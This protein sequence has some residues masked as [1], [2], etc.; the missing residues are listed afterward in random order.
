MHLERL[1]ERLGQAEHFERDVDAAS[2]G[3]LAHP[4]RRR[5]SVVAL[6]TS[7]APSRRAASSLSSRTSTAMICD[8]P[9]AV[10]NLDDVQPDAA[11]GD[12]RHAFAAAQVGA[13]ADGAVGGEHR[14]AQHRRFLRAAGSSGS[15]KTSVAGTTEYSASP[16]IEYIAIGV[17]SRAAQPRRAV[18][19]RAP[20]PVHREEVVAE[21]VAAGAAEPAAAAR[22]DER[23][24]DRACPTADR[25]R[26]ARARRRCRRSRAPAPPGV[27]KATSAFMTCRSV[28][29]TPHAVTLTSTSPASGSGIGISSMCSP[30]G[31]L[32]RTAAFIVVMGS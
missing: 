3:Q 4:R 21:I 24:G 9:N 18:V 11:G 5:R 7:V 22:H 1:R 2:V 13:V 30:P 27:G 8:A 32:S 28:W 25:R 20:Q 10:R 29:Q 15:G 19:E 14:A 31:A 26:P 17:P 23:A 16:A 6:T 12:D